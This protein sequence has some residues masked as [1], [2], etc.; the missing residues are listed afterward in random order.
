M[1]GLSPVGKGPWGGPAAAGQMDGFPV[2]TA[3]ARTERQASVNFMVRFAP[4]S[5]AAGP[6]GLKGLAESFPPLEQALPKKSERKA[7]IKSLCL[8]EGG[9]TAAWN[10]SFFKP[11]PERVAEVLKALVG[12]AARAAK[13]MGA[14]CER[15]GKD[16]P[17]ALCLADA[18]PARVCMS[19]RSVG[20][21][22]AARAK[23]AYENLQ[24]NPVLG[25]TLGIVVAAVL[26]AAW[27]GLAYGIERVFIWGGVGIG[28][29][30]AWVVNRGMGKINL[31]GRI[32]TMVLTFCSVLAGDYVAL[33]L[34]VGNQPGVGFSSEVAARVAQAFWSVEFG[35]GNGYLTLVLALVG[36]GY[37][38]FVNRLPSFKVEYEPLA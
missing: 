19:C 20:D 2:A 38:L 5:W 1:A 24:S 17:G 15:C 29:A 26:A 4:G 13:P 34:T 7:L 31:F 25:A 16:A 28:L 35:Q 37:I 21:A 3:W 33:L 9:F 27:G 22:E 11:K 14:L 12:L 32:L 23:E 6:D 8:L 30:I 36:A 10:Y 18:I